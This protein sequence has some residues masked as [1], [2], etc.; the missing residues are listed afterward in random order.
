M[1]LAIQSWDRR[2]ATLSFGSDSLEWIRIYQW[3]RFK[4]RFLSKGLFRLDSILCRIEIRLT[5]GWLGSILSLIFAML[6]SS[7]PSA[8]YW[9]GGTVLFPY[10]FSWLVEE[11]MNRVCKKDNFGTTKIQ[12]LSLHFKIFSSLISF[13]F[14]LKK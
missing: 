10:F 1:W 11:K 6:L 7:I 4:I 3:V 2:L 8:S 13:P 5:C 9:A 12:S 14:N